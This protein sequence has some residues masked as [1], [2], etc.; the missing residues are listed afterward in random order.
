MT[1]EGGDMDNDDSLFNALEHLTHDLKMFIELSLQETDAE[2][3]KWLN[4]TLKEGAVRCW[5]MK[6]CDCLQHACPA[7]HRADKRCWL[8]AG[9]RCNGK[10]QGEFSIK[11]KY[12]TECDVYRNAV[13]RDPV[14]EISEHI[15]TLIHSLKSTQDKLKT[16]AI[17]DPLTGAYNR[18]FFNEMIAN[19]IKRS[20]RYGDYFTLVM[21]DVDNFKQINDSYGHL[22]GD[23]IL[24]ECAT[25]LNKSIRDCDLL[26]R[27]GGD[28]FLIVTPATNLETC[29]ALISRVHEHLAAW[30]REPRDHDY[31]L[32]VSIGCSV[33]EKG[34]D[35]LEVI[36]EADTRMYDNKPKR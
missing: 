13:Y 24:K 8:V 20:K 28:E 18:N 35:L 25:L 21:L 7:Y 5:D 29:G 14:T 1:R 17:R 9:T 26:V 3:E 15:I 22:I 2:W 12:C 6:Q 4:V 16:L 30:N 31:G 34:K 33:F 10:I 11:Y 19:E 36:K 32:S 27:F 23:W